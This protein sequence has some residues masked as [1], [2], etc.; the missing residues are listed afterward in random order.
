MPIKVWPGTPYPLGATWTGQ[1][2]NFAVFSENATGVDVC[3][4]D[5]ADAET[6]SVRVRLTE[7]TDQVWHAFPARDPPRPALR[8]PRLRALRAGEG[9]AL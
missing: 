1:G 4:F 9:V 7:Y 5:G 3:L 6:E 2:V 8:L